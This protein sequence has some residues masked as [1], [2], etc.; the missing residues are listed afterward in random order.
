MCLTHFN[1]Y[2]SF[3]RK[4]KCLIIRMDTKRGTNMVLLDKVLCDNPTP[5]DILT[6][7]DENVVDWEEGYDEG[8]EAGKEAY[9]A[10]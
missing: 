6:D 3:W 10:K 1:S 7:W 8:Y 9:E 5:L 2:Y 4:Q